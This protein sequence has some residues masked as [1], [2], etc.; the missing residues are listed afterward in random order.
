MNDRERH[1]IW[2]ETWDT[3]DGVVTIEQRTKH[4]ASVDERFDWEQEPCVGAFGDLSG[5]TP[6]NPSSRDNQRAAMASIAPEAVRALKSIEWAGTKE[7]LGWE[8]CLFCGGHR[9]GRRCETVGGS[10]RRCELG[11]KSCNVRHVHRIGHAVDCEYVRIMDK[12]G[13]RDLVSAPRYV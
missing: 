13:A 9:E 3:I 2:E 7:D 10:S 8:C 6:F 5:A 1:P 11:T 4:Y 12:A